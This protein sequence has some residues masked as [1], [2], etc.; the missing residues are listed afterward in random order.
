[1]NIKTVVNKID[2]LNTLINAI[3]NDGRFTSYLFDFRSQEL[4]KQR[5]VLFNILESLLDKEVN[6][7]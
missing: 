4:K 6:K 3:D 1:M 5:D 7:R 2:D